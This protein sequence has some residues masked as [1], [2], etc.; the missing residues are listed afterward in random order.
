MEG[1]PMDIEEKS[2]ECHYGG[3]TASVGDVVEMK[4]RVDLIFR[5]VGDLAHLGFWRVIAVIT[6]DKLTTVWESG[7]NPNLNMRAYSKGDGSRTKKTHYGKNKAHSTE[8]VVG[9]MRRLGSGGRFIKRKNKKGAI[10]RAASASI[11]LSISTE[12][13]NNR[14]RI[15]LNE[16]QA[17]WEMGKA[18]GLV[19]DG[20]N[21]NVICKIVELE[22]NDER[23]YEKMKGATYNR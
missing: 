4:S 12:S 9:A 20:S 23:Q 11:V 7:F 13:I 19:E 21:E 18:L 16:A 3:S 5:V 22:E 14:G 1:D 10:F 2:G 15:M 6:D 17:T 8:R